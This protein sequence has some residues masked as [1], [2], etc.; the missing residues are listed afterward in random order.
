MQRRPALIALIVACAFFM[1]QLDG[2][3]IA[4]ALPQMARSF[5]E[6]PVDVSLGMTAYLLTLAVFIPVS[7]W[8]ADRFGAR[9]I[10]RAAVLVFTCA[11][12]A[13]GF[14]G[15]LWEFVIARVVQGIG[16]AMMVPVGRL[17]V[18][19]TSEKHEL[20]R[21]MA[22][23]TTPGLVATVVGPPVGGFITT[24]ASWRWIFFLNVPIGIVGLV[25]IT[26]LM[27]NPKGEHQ[28]P[29]DPLGFVLTGTALA[30]IMYGVN[31]AGRPGTSAVDAALFAVLGLVVGAFA[32]YHARRSAAPMLDLRILR[33]RSFAT[34][35]LLT[36]SFYRVVIGSTPLLWPL[37]FQLG[38]GMSAFASG[39]LIV[40]C[41]VGDVAMK[42]VTSRILR[43]FGFRNVLV[44]NGLLVTALIVLSGSFTKTTPTLVIIV[45]LLA[46]GMSRSTQF[47]TLNAL[48]YVEIPSGMMSAA[49]SLASTA[50]QISFGIGIAFG[51][52]AL[53]GAVLLRGGT[54]GAFIETDFRLAFFAVGVIGLL[55]VLGC[56]RLDPHVGADVSGHRHLETSEAQPAS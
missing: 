6:S 28:R 17:V 11:S 27:P 7:G 24:Y 2:T 53:H 1:E 22:F 15:T 49:S 42:A 18:L 5:H 52:L 54:A 16:G 32:V 56:L 19:R 35:T 8:I 44:G 38:F 4:T 10:F 55:S 36:G 41:A 13:C 48:A 25:L 43:R 26:L 20:I 29:F 30:S 14:S 21:S 33:Y 37:M 51:A 12:I 34:S 40:A 3:V 46:V 39:L 50:Q 45:V 23:I 31:L 47:T 9:T